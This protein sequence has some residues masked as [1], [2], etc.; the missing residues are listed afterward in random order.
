MRKYT[1]NGQYTHVFIS[2]KSADNCTICK[3]LT[4][5]FNCPKSERFSRIDNLAAGNFER[6]I[7]SGKHWKCVKFIDETG[8]EYS[9]A[10]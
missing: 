10:G 9:I 2:V 3:Q 7:R 6:H 5:Y 8:K 1:N 4:E